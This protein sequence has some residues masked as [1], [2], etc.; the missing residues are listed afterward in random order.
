M[1][2]QETILL[3]V[4][5]DTESDS[6]AHRTSSTFATLGGRNMIR[7]RK[8]RPLRR[9]RSRLIR[10]S[11]RLMRCAVSF[12]RHS[13]WV[14]WKVGPEDSHQMCSTEK[15]SSGMMERKMRLRMPS[16]L[17]SHLFFSSFSVLLSSFRFSLILPTFPISSSTLSSPMSKNTPFGFGSFLLERSLHVSSPAQLSDSAMP[18]LHAYAYA[19]YLL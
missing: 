9:L 16:T 6:T 19:L 3:I 7:R 1:Y 17:S 12:L 13:R 15:I 5:G 10:A 2:W 8:V 14:K 4:R 18:R 11:I